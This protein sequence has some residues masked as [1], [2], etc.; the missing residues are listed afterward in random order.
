MNFENASDAH[1]E[2]MRATVKRAVLAISQG[3]AVG[4]HTAVAEQQ[5]AL[6]QAI[7]L[8]KQAFRADKLRDKVGEYMSKGGLLSAVYMGI[9]KAQEDADIPKEAEPGDNATTAMAVACAELDL[10]EFLNILVEWDP[11]FRMGPAGTKATVE[12]T[13]DFFLQFGAPKCAAHILER[14]SVLANAMRDTFV[15]DNHVARLLRNAAAI[16]AKPGLH[17]ILEAGLLDIQ[18]RGLPVIVDFSD[19]SP[20]SCFTLGLSLIGKPEGFASATAE[21]GK[22]DVRR[23]EMY[24]KQVLRGTWESSASLCVLELGVDHP[25]AQLHAATRHLRKDDHVLR[26][27]AVGELD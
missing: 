18:D 20:S 1:V 11:H 22:K 23:L 4:A 7:A 14:R 27:E 26:V 13:A 10:P 15:E 2:A 19:K 3:D 6:P 12:T 5:I 8:L 25:I 24:T 9:V 17:P 21:T 16:L